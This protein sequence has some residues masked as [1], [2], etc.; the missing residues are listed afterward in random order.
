MALALQPN[1]VL[2]LILGCLPCRQVAVCRGICK[3]FEKTCH[4]HCLA[5]QRLQ[6]QHVMELGDGFCENERRLEAIGVCTIDLSPYEWRAWNMAWKLLKHENRHG[7]AASDHRQSIIHTWL[8]IYRASQTTASSSDNGLVY[9]MILR[10]R[11]QIQLVAFPTIGT[12]GNQESTSTIRLCHLALYEC[13]FVKC[14]HVIM[15]DKEGRCAPLIFGEASLVDV[16][17]QRYCTPKRNWSCLSGSPMQ[18][19]P[20]SALLIVLLMMQPGATVSRN[21]NSPSFIAHLASH[22]LQTPSSG[23][24]AK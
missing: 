22:R 4:A 21:V 12:S 14:L 17:I 23:K 1:V 19:D 16:A 24:A 13:S 2:D 7:I 3:R 15:Q 11:C 10:Y 6:W 9:W 18:F 5:M 20:R 8:P